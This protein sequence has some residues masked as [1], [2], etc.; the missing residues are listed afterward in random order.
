MVHLFQ[1]LRNQVLVTKGKG[2]G[3][4]NNDASL[5]ASGKGAEALAVAL[6]SPA[7]FKEDGLGSLP[8]KVES[9]AHKDC[10]ILRLG[11]HLEVAAAGDYA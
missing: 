2:I 8:K 9:K 5:T 7:V 6:Q 4:H 10:L 1:G 3:V 11:E